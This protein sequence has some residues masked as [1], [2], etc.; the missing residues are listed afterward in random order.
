MKWWEKAEQ[1]AE[2]YSKFR[3]EYLCFIPRGI[4]DMHASYIGALAL[5][6][7][8]G[9]ATPMP[10]A[11][12]IERLNDT[13]SAHYFTDIGALYSG[14]KQQVDGIWYFNVETVLH[15]PLE[16]MRTYYPDVKWDRIKSG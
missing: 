11:H 12:S 9:P 15:N 8:V 16:I 2:R 5:E 14:P 4:L 3:M 1:T 10:L 6:D 7:Q 13:L